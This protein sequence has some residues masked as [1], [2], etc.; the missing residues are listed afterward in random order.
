MRVLYLKLSG[1]QLPRRSCNVYHELVEHD[2][3]ESNPIASLGESKDAHTLSTTDQSK[4]LSS[5]SDDISSGTSVKTD[6][7]GDNQSNCIPNLSSSELLPS[8]SLDETSDEKNELIVSDESFVS[9][10]G[11][12]RLTDEE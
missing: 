2:K 12:L 6:L 5:T 7:D 11:E 4:S 1:H 10:L 8:H 9:E 3:S